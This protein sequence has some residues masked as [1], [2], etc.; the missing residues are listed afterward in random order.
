MTRLVSQ[1]FRLPLLL[2]SAAF[3][4]FFVAC[5]GNAANTSQ[6][7]PTAIPLPV[8]AEK[9]TYAVQR[10]EMIH[11]LAFSGRIAPVEQQELAFGAGGRI[12]KINVRRGDTVKKDQLLAELELGQDEYARRRAEANLEIARL[13]LELARLQ[14]PQISEVNRL[15][16]AIQ[17]QE[18][19]LAQIALDEINVTYDGLRITSP[20]D[21]TV[22]SISILEGAIIEANKPVIVIANLDDLVV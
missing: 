17:E 10:G 16:I 1:L 4:L 18:V 19:E 12:A 9:Q 5:S 21:G 7:T 6:P 3:I 15:T 14:Y 13:R 20:M 22:L 8:I 11:E 2:I